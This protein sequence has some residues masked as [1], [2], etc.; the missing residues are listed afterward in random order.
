ME[1]E[2]EKALERVER[3]FVVALTVWAT[4]AF[5]AAYSGAISKV[6]RLILGP[7][8]LTE[9]VIPILVY[10]LSKSFR[11]YIASIDLKHLT[12]FH[13][14]RLLA[15]FAFVSYGIQHLLPE[16]F[17]HN[18]GFG[19]I[20]VGLLVPVILILPNGIR[21][22]IVFHIIG[23]LDFILALGTGITLTLS[24]AP[25]IEN[26]TTY[27]IILIPLIGVP[28]SGALHVMAIDVALR[29]LRKR[30]LS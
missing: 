17:V 13:L 23:L 14:W 12:I 30:R 29:K 22:Y 18:A 15:G 4:C 26:L 3:W 5:I 9:T 28:L 27:P 19:D 7:L 21:K 16:T 25:L 2:N 6:P 20:I 24:R 10:Y 8:L 11:A 1:L